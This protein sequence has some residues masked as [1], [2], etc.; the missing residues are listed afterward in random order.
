MQVSKT[1]YNDHPEPKD[2]KSHTP[3]F[4]YRNRPLQHTSQLTSPLKCGSATV[5][6]S[7]SGFQITSTASTY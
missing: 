3:V 1:G 5:V 4:D 2:S 6:T 7:P